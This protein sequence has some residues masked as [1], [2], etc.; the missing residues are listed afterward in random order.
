MRL[1]CPDP[2]P[3]PVKC[4]FHDSHITELYEVMICPTLRYEFVLFAPLSCLWI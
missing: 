2:C 1:G 4:Y 3:F